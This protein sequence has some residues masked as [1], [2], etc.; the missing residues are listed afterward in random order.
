[1]LHEVLLALLGFPGDVIQRSAEDD[2]FQVSRSKKK[3]VAG[4]GEG[5]E[6]ALVLDMLTEAEQVSEGSAEKHSSL[7]LCCTDSLSVSFIVSG[8]LRDLFS[9]FSKYIIIFFFFSCHHLFPRIVVPTVNS[10]LNYMSSGAN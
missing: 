8:C 4:N 7:L 10:S 9:H 6:A 5:R 1:M 2:C 3:E